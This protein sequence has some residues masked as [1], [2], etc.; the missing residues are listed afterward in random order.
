MDNCI[1]ELHRSNLEI[2]DHMLSAKLSNKG[3]IYQVKPPSKEASDI[4][5]LAAREITFS[6]YSAAPQNGLRSNAG[7]HL[8]P[9]AGAT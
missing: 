9:E 3:E 7:A 1:V 5:V 8:L 2:W 6:E 4:G